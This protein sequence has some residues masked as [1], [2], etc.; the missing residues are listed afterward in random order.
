MHFWARR[1]I[2]SL[3]KCSWNNIVEDSSQRQWSGIQTKAGQHMARHM[4]TQN[5]IFQLELCHLKF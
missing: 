4:L 5:G 1:A 3:G 2:R